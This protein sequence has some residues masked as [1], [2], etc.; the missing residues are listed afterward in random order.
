MLLGYDERQF[1]DLPDW[2]LNLRGYYWVVRVEGR[3]QAK[4]RKYYRLIE[5][6]KLRLAEMGICQ[7]KISAVCRYLC[8]FKNADNLRFLLAEP[9]VQLS[10]NFL[11]N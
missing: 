5:R 6:E 11:F 7:K 3:I 10:F 4:R 2:S 8:N 9:D 1:V